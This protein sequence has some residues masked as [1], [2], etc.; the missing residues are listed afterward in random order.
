MRTDQIIAEIAARQHGVVSR[1]QL[2]EAGVTPGRIARRTRSLALRPVHFGVYQVGPIAGPL[3]RE[4][5]AALACGAG[6]VVSHTSAAA[7][8]QILPGCTSQPVEVTIRADRGR[9]AGISRHHVGTHH[10]DEVTHV[11][12]LPVTTAARTLLDLG[13]RLGPTALERLAALAE[14]LGLLTTQDLRT[15]AERH[16]GHR[17]VRTL[18]QLCALTELAFTRSE[19]EDRLLSLIRR[20]R[21]AVPSTNAKIGDYEVDFVWR[22]E[23][24]VVEVDGFAFHASARAFERDRSRDAM[25][26]ANGYRVIRVTWRQL[27]REPDAVLAS[28]AQALVRVQS[29]AG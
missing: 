28:I 7:V 9:R 15:M 26:V 11:D 24:L 2:L 3:A 13:V 19:A 17:G 23:R 16:R 6:A 8:W 27:T 22:A 14:R 18:N 4:F 25:L 21:L 20:G 29:A 10:D 5:A 12:G 1:A